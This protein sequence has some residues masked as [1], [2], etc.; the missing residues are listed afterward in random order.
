MFQ[1]FCQAEDI[2]CVTGLEKNISFYTHTQYHIFTLNLITHKSELWI[3]ISAHLLP[4]QK[5]ILGY[6]RFYY[7]DHVFLFVLTVVK[8]RYIF[9]REGF[10]NHCGIVLL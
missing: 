10:C 4:L 7:S 6:L 9:V 8:T 5:L 1:C 2:A 3:C